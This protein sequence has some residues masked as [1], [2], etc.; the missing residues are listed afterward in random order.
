MPFVWF[1]PCSNQLKADWNILW[2]RPTPLYENLS[3]EGHDG[4]LAQKNEQ[5]YSLAFSHP[6][7]DEYPTGH[8]HN[9]FGSCCLYYNGLPIIVDVGRLD[10]Q[11][12]TSD[13]DQGVSAE[14]HNTVILDGQS[15]LPILHVKEAFCHLARIQC[16]V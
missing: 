7:K 10:Y 3:G 14:M 9:D 12:H 16:R 13:Q 15:V 4:W 6:A 2:N 11:V 1:S 5:W 8:G